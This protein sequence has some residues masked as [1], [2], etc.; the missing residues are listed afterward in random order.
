MELTAHAIPAALVAYDAALENVPPT[1]GNRMFAMR[2]AIEGY[3]DAARRP[4]P[5]QPCQ[6]RRYGDEMQCGR[7]GLAWGVGDDDR[8]D[9]SPTERRIA[10]RRGD[11]A[12]EL[13][14][15]DGL[16]GQWDRP[17]A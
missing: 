10:A 17:A 14:E 16:V 9:C 1:T 12:L 2:K 7:C 15:P 3:V 4:A 6:A 5:P 13:F 11:A 8:P